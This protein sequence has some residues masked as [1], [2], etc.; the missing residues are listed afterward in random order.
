M[1]AE[2]SL[3]REIDFDTRLGTKR[4]SRESEAKSKDSSYLKKRSEVFYTFAQHISKTYQGLMDHWYR[5]NKLLAGCSNLIINWGTQI[6]LSL[7]WD[8]HARRIETFLKADL[9][10]GQLLLLS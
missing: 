6:E 1:N 9:A 7:Y 5:K 2:E 8:W 4:E 10:E 3:A